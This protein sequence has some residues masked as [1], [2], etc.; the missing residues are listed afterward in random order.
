MYAYLVA[1]EKVAQKFEFFKKLPKV[2]SRPI[3]DNSSNLVTL[4]LI[5]HS[6]D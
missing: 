5:L 6:I 2:N 3:G 1:K 4:L